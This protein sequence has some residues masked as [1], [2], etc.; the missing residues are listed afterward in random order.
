MAYERFANGGLS[1]LDAAIDNDDLALTVKSAVGF[2][3]GGNFRI[4]VDNEIMLVTDVQGKTFTV[5]RAQEGTSAAAHDADAAVFHVLTAGALAV[6]VEETPGQKD[7]EVLLRHGHERA[8][9]EA[10]AAFGAPSP[11][12]GPLEDAGAGRPLAEDDLRVGPVALAAVG[13]LQVIDLLARVGRVDRN[14]LC[15]T[16]HVARRDTRRRRPARFVNM[17]VLVC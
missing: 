11:V 10:Q 14:H 5:A 17:A 3:T 9:G 6:L 15:P 13:H 1:S 4:I 12:R 7:G 2:P 8:A 16:V